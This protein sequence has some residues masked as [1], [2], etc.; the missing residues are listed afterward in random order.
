MMDTGL[1][2]NLGSVRIQ[3]FILGQVCCQSSKTNPSSFL[4]EFLNELFCLAR[5]IN[6]GTARPGLEAEADPKAFQG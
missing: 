3:I 4:L 2:A 5:G 1:F 6:S